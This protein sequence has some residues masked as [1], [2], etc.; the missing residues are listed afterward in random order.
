MARNKSILTEA[1]QIE[2]AV[3]LIQL[4]PLA[5]HVPLPPSSGVSVT[6]FQRVHRRASAL[7]SGSAGSEQKRADSYE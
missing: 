4:G 3:T 5:A 6:Q 1:R 7:F 2:R